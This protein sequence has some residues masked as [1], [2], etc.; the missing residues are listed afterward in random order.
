[1]ERRELI[2]L[3]DNLC[4]AARSCGHED[5]G[6]DD[7]GVDESGAPAEEDA[8]DSYHP[9]AVEYADRVLALLNT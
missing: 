7:F 8:D 1:M 3:L 5:V 6:L 9:E 2:N 4:W